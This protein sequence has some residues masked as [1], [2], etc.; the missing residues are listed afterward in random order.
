MKK[1]IL[2]TDNGL[3]LPCVIFPTRKQLFPL[4]EEVM[5]YC[6]NRLIKGYMSALDDEL[7]A[8][9]EVI[10]DYCSI[11]ELDILLCTE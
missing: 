4:G 8:E 11:P 9:L 10:V 6:Q 7:V 3:E 5:V 2:I 1:G